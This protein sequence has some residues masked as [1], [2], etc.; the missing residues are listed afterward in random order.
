MHSYW[1]NHRSW[2]LWKQRKSHQTISQLKNLKRVQFCFSYTTHKF[3]SFNLALHWDNLEVPMQHKISNIKLSK[4]IPIHFM[5]SLHKCNI[6]VLSKLHTV[7]PNGHLIIKQ[8]M[9]FRPELAGNCYLLAS[10]I[11]FATYCLILFNF[12]NYLNILIQ[13]F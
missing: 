6:K 8:K 1:I 11:T 9:W 2:C 12:F 10:N 3:A 4:W 5:C 13:I 7:L